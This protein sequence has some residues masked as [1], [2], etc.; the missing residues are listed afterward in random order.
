MKALQNKILTDGIVL[1]DTVLK[2][3]TFLNHQMDPVL[4]KEI[5]KNSLRVLKMQE[6]R[7]F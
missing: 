4:M 6:L 1:S 7:R 3:D 5:E 2:V